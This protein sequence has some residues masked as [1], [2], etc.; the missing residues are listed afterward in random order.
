MDTMSSYLKLKNIMPDIILSSC[1][2]RTQE[3]ADILANKLE[4]KNK[5]EYLKELYYT[6]TEVLSDIIKMQ[7]NSINTI[8]VI[9]HNPQLTDYANQITNEHISKIPSSGIA[10]IDFEIES[11][12][13]VGDIKGKLD[14]FITPKQFKYYMPKQIRAY[15]ET[16]E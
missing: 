12:D 10:C 2:L 7:D 4:Y 15:L 14:F 8:F 3:S 6:P 13:Q 5:I 9:G 1:S 16:K 11:W